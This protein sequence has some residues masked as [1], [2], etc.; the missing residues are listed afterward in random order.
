MKTKNYNPYEI[1]VSDI[2]QYERNKYLERG[3]HVTWEEIDELYDF[4][5]QFFL[6]A[7]HKPFLLHSEIQGENKYLI[8]SVLND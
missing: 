6:K 2:W 3:S 8:N 4:V 5:E 7:E 1:D